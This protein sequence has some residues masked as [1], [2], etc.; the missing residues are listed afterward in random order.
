MRNNIAVLHAYDL[1]IGDDLWV[2]N[3]DLNQCAMY[4]LHQTQERKKYHEYGI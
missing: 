2:R 4:D 3:S 1:V